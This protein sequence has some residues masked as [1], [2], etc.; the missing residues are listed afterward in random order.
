MGPVRYSL[1]GQH[2]VYLS[3]KKEEGM[4]IWKS[5]CHVIL[6]CMSI[7]STIIIAA[8][9]THETLRDKGIMRFK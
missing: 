6:M 8:S 3:D 4:E 1:W 7:T 9:V 5:S 2:Q